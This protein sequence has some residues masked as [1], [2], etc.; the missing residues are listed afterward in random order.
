MPWNGSVT[1]HRRVAFVQ[2]PLDDV[3]AVKNALGGTVNDVVL[4]LSAGAI[5]SY[6]QRHDALPDGPLV[7][8]VPV[9]VRRPDDQGSFG[10]QVANMTVRL[11]THLADPVE[12]LRAVSAGTAVAKEELQAVGADAMG[13]WAELAAPRLLAQAVRLASRLRLADV[14]QPVVNLVVS[15][16]PGP[17]FPLWCA[18]AKLE[19]MYPMAGVG[20]G[21]G[22]NMTLISYLGQVNFGIV[23]CREAVP[24]LELLADALPAALAEL[25]S[26]AGL[27]ATGPSPKTA[28]SGSRRRAKPA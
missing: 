10:N 15:N 9:S 18:G 12:R 13:D 20:E 4:A 11:P 23:A 25:R 14:T 28:R 27:D 19:A 21:T 16:V 5:R 6:L 1:A 3:K 26:A 2:V 7:V 17:S 8:A 22:L 24:D